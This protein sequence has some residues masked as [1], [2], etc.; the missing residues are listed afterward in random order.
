[1][2]YEIEGDLLMR[3]TQ[4]AVLAH[5]GVKRKYSGEP[6]VFHPIR[7]A[8]MLRKALPAKTHPQLREEVMVAGLLH[9]VLEDT[10]ATEEQLVRLFGPAVRALVHELTDKTVLVDG[11]RATRHAMDRERLSKVSDLAKLIKLADVIDNV[12]SIAESDPGFAKKYLPEKW[13]LLKVLRPAVDAAHL[14]DKAIA[15]ISAGISKLGI[16]Y[17][18]RFEWL[19]A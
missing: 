14:R 18:S 15:L 9:D 19:V 3:A 2:A 12:A 13:E 5:Q 7:V 17:D 8:E 6:Y 16:D 11:N 4:F 10:A 1:M